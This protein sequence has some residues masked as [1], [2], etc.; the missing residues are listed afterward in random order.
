MV[1]SKINFSF[2]QNNCYLVFRKF[3]Y[4]KNTLIF[5]LKLNRN[6]I[7]NQKYINPF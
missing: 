3:E 5:E 4:P 6:H 7:Q 2:K 1:S